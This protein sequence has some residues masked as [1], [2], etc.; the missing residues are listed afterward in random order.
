MY[1]EIKHP[2]FSS[3]LWERP[4]GY[5][6]ANQLPKEGYMK[7]QDFES[8]WGRNFFRW[9]NALSEVEK[10]AYRKDV[11]LRMKAAAQ[12]HIDSIGAYLNEPTL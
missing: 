3:S 7:E 2:E 9:F 11:D 1:R 4:C 12:N 10:E 6:Y 5:N 8:E